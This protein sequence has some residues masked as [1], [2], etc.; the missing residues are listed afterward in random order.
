MKLRFL[1]A[2]HGGEL[3]N[4]PERARTC[5][6]TSLDTGYLLTE[7]GFFEEALPHLGCAF[8]AAEIIFSARGTERERAYS[9]F[10]TATVLLSRVYSALNQHEQGA[11][12]CQLAVR[13]LLREASLQPHSEQAITRQLQEIYRY[14]HQ[15][16]S[17]PVQMRVG[18][19]KA[20]RPAHFATIH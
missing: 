18:S 1:C 2:A 15:K 16:P 17:V 7:R 14:T 13:R 9:M 11:H 3:A 6:E 10:T 19:R 5:F 20:S 4:S 12:I 8:E